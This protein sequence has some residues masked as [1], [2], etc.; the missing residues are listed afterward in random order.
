MNEG[1]H[2]SIFVEW[3]TAGDEA[4]EV[5]NIPFISRV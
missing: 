2:Y 4:D 1:V 5:P 3:E